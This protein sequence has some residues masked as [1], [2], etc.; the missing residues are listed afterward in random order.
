M[1]GKQIWKYT[2][3][4]ANGFKPGLILANPVATSDGMVYLTSAGE[5]VQASS[6]TIK[7]RGHLHALKPSDG[8]VSGK[9]NTSLMLKWTFVADDNNSFTFSPQLSTSTVSVASNNNSLYS[10]NQA[11]GALVFR[12]AL[13]DGKILAQPLLASDGSAY[14]PTEKMG[15]I[16][17]L[18]N[19]SMAFQFTSTYIKS[20]GHVENAIKFGTTPIL[21][22][23]GGTLYAAMD[24]PIL[25]A[26]NTGNGAELWRYQML[27]DIKTSA[28]LDADGAVFVGSDGKDLAILTPAG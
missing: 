11:S 15:L 24:G 14:I 23:D 9:W 1:T 5:T 25:F 21:S 10:L 12:F 2:I 8:F 13:S 7:P 20:D 17:V 27:G 6:G 26:V 3:K 16:H 18:P 28:S 22:P 19:G 4:G